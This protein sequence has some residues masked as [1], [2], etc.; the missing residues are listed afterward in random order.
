[1]PKK[2][3]R[4]PTEVEVFQAINTF[5]VSLEEEIATQSVADLETY[6]NENG[7]SIEPSREDL[8]TG[9]ETARNRLRLSVA[10]EARLGQEN[11]VRQNAVDHIQRVSNTLRLQGQALRNEVQRRL[12]ALGP[13]AVAMYGRNFEEAD[14]DDLRTILETLARLEEGEEP[15]RDVDAQ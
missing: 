13:Q 15:N 14:D 11:A 1:M 9:I 5:T 3:N 6:L 10:R 8:K 12:G 7:I 4:Q 2:E